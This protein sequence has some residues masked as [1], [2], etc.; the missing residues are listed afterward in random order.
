M[1]CDAF[2][3][4]ALYAIA[5]PFE[6]NKAIQ[7]ESA[8]S[9]RSALVLVCLFEVGAQGPWAQGPR[10]LGPFL[11]NDSARRGFVV[12]QLNASQCNTVQCNPI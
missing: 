8:P 10:G 2:C 6:F 11:L 4:Y 3:H 1:R 7:I 5:S 9:A 12:V